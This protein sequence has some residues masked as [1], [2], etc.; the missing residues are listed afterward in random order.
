VFVDILISS[1]AGS[2]FRTLCLLLSFGD[3]QTCIC[4]SFFPFLFPFMAA[5]KKVKLSA[6][7]EGMELTMNEFID[8]CILLGCDYCDTIRGIGPVKAYDLIKKHK[9]IEEILKHIDQT[10]YPVSVT[11]T[12]LPHTYTP[13]FM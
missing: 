9:S 6:V 2:F 4:F 11:F 10:K 1:F 7:L 3:A 12:S 13:S 5:Q 8:L